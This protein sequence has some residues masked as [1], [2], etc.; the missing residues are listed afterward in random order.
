MAPFCLCEGTALSTC[1]R[2]Q[3]RRSLD[4]AGGLAQQQR[5]LQV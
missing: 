3:G 1:G 5:L 4:G 2:W